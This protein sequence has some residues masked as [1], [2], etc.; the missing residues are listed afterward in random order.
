MKSSTLLKLGFL[1]L[2]MSF[3]VL[4][5]TAQRTTTP[6]RTTKA[7][8]AATKKGIS[9][10]DQ[11]AIKEIFQGVDQSKYRLQFNNKTETLGTRNVSMN[12]IRQVK[13]ITNPGEAAGWIVFVV[14][15]DDVVYV[16]A[17]GSSDLVSVIGKEKALK[18]NQI[19]AKYQ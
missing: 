6:T 1:T 15:G 10:A 18:L 12:D 17:V 19:M 8:T 16:L 3:L 5:A 4:S 13:K 14:E 11:K 9:A 7:T 2:L